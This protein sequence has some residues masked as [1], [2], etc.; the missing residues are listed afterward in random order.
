MGNTDMLLKIIDLAVKIIALL[1]G[2]TWAL[3]KIKEYRE[4]KNWIQ[5]DLDAN[6]YKLT[7]P[8]NAS[9]LS[10]DK[11]GNCDK[12]K[13]ELQTHAIE[14]MLKFSNKG[15]TR[16]KMFNVQIGINTMREPEKAKFN[17][18]DGRLC[19]TRVL[20]TGNLVPEFQVK[21]KKI[22]D[23]SFYYIEP[24]VEQKISHLCLIPEPGELLKITGY[25][26]IEQK[27]IFP[28]PIEKSSKPY[29]HTVARTF[30]IPFN[31]H[32]KANKT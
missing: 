20:T 19:L 24:G 18:N 31:K 3:Y 5:F 17:E 29:T 27:R 26:N 7:N 15:K 22:E 16:V 14:V 32:T 13:P 2:G 6:I 1:I 25:Y 8:E 28:K 10:W 12:L 9:V 21:N 23:T 4:F 11:N 30:Q